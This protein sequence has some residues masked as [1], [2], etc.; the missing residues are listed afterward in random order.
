MKMQLHSAGV[1]IFFYFN[2]SYDLKKWF[3]SIYKYKTKSIFNICELVG[4][5]I[6]DGIELLITSAR[7]V[8]P[9]SERLKYFG[10]DVLTKLKF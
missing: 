6:V 2:F 8:H 5:G 1:F 3:R 4:V 7:Y 9:F 10:L